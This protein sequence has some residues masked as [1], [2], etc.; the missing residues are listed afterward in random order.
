MKQF[1]A[2]ALVGVIFAFSPR[3]AADEAE[4]KAVA[5]IERLGGRIS[6]ENPD[7]PASPVVEVDL[8]GVK[9]AAEA[10]A[11]L[12]RL[13]DLQFLLLN[14]T[15]ITDNDLL[16]VKSLRKLVRLE[17]SETNITDTG[18]ASLRDLPELRSL[19]LK[20]TSITGTGLVHFKGHEK[21]QSL[22]LDASK[23]TD[24]SVELLKQCKHLPLASFFQLHNQ[25]EY[26]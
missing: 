11:D 19:S 23:I 24:K 9:K 22:S 17:L 5:T 2:L 3:A 18:L 21:L 7:K 8:T 10:L 15:T 20:N 16:H 25:E 12:A 6:R 1:L 13:Q 26:K 14:R 4:N